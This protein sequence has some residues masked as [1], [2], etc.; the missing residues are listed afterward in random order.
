MYLQ[1]RSRGTDVVNKCMETKREEGMNWETG[2]DVYT[3]LCMKQ[4]TNKN[5]LCSTGNSTQ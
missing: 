2:I 1:S 3:L 4:I 5:L